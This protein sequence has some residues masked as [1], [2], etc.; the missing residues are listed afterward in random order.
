MLRSEPILRSWS[1][2]SRSLPARRPHARRRFTLERL[3]ERSL[4]STIALTVNTLADDPSGPTTGQTTLR[5]AINTAD[6]HTNNSYTIK[7]AIDGTI[8]LSQALP[9]L[10]NN[11]NIQGPGASKLT[12]QR[13]LNASSFSV[14]IVGNGFGSFNAN[15]TNTISGITIAG[16]NDTWGGGIGNYGI[17]TVVNTIFIGNY[18]NFGGGLYRDGALTISGSTFTNNSS[19]FGGAIHNITTMP[20]TITDSTFSNNTGGGI[21]NAYDTVVITNSTFIGNTAPASA[22]AIGGGAITNQGGMLTVNHSTFTNN[23][24]GNGV[25]GDAISNYILP[26]Y[27]GQWP[28]T[29]IIVNSTFTGNTAT[30]GGAIY[31]SGKLTVTNN[32]F[33]GNTASTDGGGVDNDAGGT[34]SVTGS[35]FI[36]NTAANGGGIE[37]DGTATVFNSIFAGNSAGFGGGLSYGGTATVIDSL[38]VGNSA[39]DDG[40]GIYN[41]GTL[42]NT[43]NLFFN[44]TGGN[45]N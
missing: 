33:I 38:F 37:N 2:I 34:A 45:I 32:T 40:G 4:L 43:S 17:L 19:A 41:L 10:T 30:D 18:A 11:I 23:I 42:I 27:Y 8:A 26:S 21:Y 24:T 25:H 28:N 20:M 3:E 6:A 13:D 16:G 22:P 7:F 31:N 15:I 29:V 9:N 39:T 1:A 35:T 12:V 5:D 36:N 14:F 44:N